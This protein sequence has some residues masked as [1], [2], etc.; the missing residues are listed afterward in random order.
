VPDVG[1]VTIPDN[2]YQQQLAKIQPY[3]P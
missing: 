2:L 3:L 1:Y